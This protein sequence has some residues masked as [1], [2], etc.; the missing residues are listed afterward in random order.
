MIAH[1]PQMRKITVV[2]RCPRLARLADNGLVKFVA[3]C[4]FIAAAPPRPATLYSFS[5]N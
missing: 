5:A 4:V 1:T 2:A 3:H